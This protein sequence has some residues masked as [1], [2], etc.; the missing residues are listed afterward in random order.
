MAQKSVR[1]V[2]TATTG[3]DSP[4]EGGR[5]QEGPGG[6]QLPS[7]A[8]G[9]TRRQGPGCA[10]L[11]A[12]E[13]GSC[14]LR[15]RGSEGLGETVDTGVW[16]DRLMVCVTAVRPN[17]PENRP[18]LSTLP[19]APGGRA[20]VPVGH[21]LCSRAR[22]AGQPPSV[23]RHP[24]RHQRAHSLRKPRFMSS[25]SSSS[26]SSSAELKVPSGRL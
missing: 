6:H 1:D 8:R 4:S 21:G 5:L 11:S 9:Q 13:P 17:L 24:A 20:S 16:T 22:P 12:A 7:A 23:V 14:W 2:P 19:G 3:E 15:S 25:S 10:R 18:Q 26:S